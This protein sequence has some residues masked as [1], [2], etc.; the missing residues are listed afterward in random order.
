[1]SGKT[2]ENVALVLDEV[3]AKIPAPTPLPLPQIVEESNIPA[4]QVINSNISRC[5]IFD[6]VFDP[7]K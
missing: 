7:Y 5:L 2:G 4:R 1:M 3:I 6:S